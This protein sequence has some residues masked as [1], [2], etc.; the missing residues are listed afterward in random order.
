MLAHERRGCGNLGETKAFFCTT[1]VAWEVW[2]EQSIVC[3]SRLP[4]APWL[5]RC[6][7]SA[8]DEVNYL[9]ASGG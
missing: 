7:L 9:G 2:Y 5:I 6:Y 3:K 1:S 4:F 8:E